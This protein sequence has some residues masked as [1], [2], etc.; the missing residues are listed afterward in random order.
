LQATEGVDLT[1]AAE[2]LAAS[3]REAGALALSMFQTPLKNW[4]KGAASS[5]VSDADIAVDNLLRERLMS[6]GGIVLLSV[7]HTLTAAM[8]AAEGSTRQATTNLPLFSG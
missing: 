5:P 3:V 1:R 7:A 2:R 6:G 8:I 4:T